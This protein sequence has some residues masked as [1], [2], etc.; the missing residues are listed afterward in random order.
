MRQP[1]AP[2]FL[3]SRP[4]GEHRRREGPAREKPPARVFVNFLTFC[5]VK[6]SKKKLEI[7]IIQQEKHKAKNFELNNNGKIDRIGKL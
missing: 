4:N 1:R 5:F 7:K 6:L 2:G 3:F